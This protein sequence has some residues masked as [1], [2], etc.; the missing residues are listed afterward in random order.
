MTG[1]GGC[2]WYIFQIFSNIIYIFNLLFQFFIAMP[3]FSSTI[4]QLGQP[5]CS[6]MKGLSAD[7]QSNFLFWCGCR[8]LSVT[9]EFLL[10]VTVLLYGR[11]RVAQFSIL[12]EYIAQVHQGLYSRFEILMSYWLCSS[13]SLIATMVM[14]FTAQKR[15]FSLRIS[16]FF[17]QRLFPLLTVES[18][19]LLCLCHLIFL[20]MYSSMIFQ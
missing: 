20:Y 18:T 15:S 13:L 14:Y 8:N 10:L 4:Q 1:V 3:W 16:S 17:V 5:L 9:L 19:F 2:F 11:M 6:W 7:F 12:Q